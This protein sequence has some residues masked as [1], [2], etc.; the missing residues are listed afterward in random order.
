M[1]REMQEEV[2]TASDTLPPMGGR[3][4]PHFSALPPAGPGLRCQSKNRRHPS[5]R[6]PCLVMRSLPAVFVLAPNRKPP[7]SQ[8]KCASLFPG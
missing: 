2:D 5:A 3:V 6:S 1:N 8:A 7:G 4:V